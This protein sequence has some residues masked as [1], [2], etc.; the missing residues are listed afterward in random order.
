MDGAKR[1]ETVDIKLGRTT[2]IPPP[3]EGG[4]VEVQF[5]KR[6]GRYKLKIVRGGKVQHQRLTGPKETA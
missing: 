5:I 4:E 2:K 1:P 6:R 3:G